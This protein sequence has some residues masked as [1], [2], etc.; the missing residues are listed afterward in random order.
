MSTTTIH[1]SHTSEENGHHEDALGYLEAMVANPNSSG[2][3][4]ERAWAAVTEGVVAHRKTTSCDDPGAEETMELSVDDEEAIEALERIIPGDNN[5]LPV[6]FL[7]RGVTTQKAV[8]RIAL[9][10]ARGTLPAGAGWGT[11]WLVANDLL[12]TNNHVMPTARDA[13]RLRAEFN[14]QNKVDGTPDVADVY[15]FDPDSFFLTNRELDYTVVRVSCRNLFVPNA[16][17][18]LGVASNG[19][20]QFELVDTSESDLIGF[21]PDPN[22]PAVPPAGLGNLAAQLGLGLPG[23]R[24]RF[25]PICVK[26]GSRWG[27]ISLPPGRIRLRNKMHLNVVQHPRGRRKEIAMQQNRLDRQFGNVIRYT[28]DTEPG[29]SGSPVFNNSWEVLALHH[30]GGDKVD[31]EWVNNEGIRIDRIVDDVQRRLPVGNSVRR[32]LGV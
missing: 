15:D 1:P 6:A 25:P 13:H 30:A 11:G 20:I 14:Y 32:Q 19:E 4:I 10:Q 8:A 3:A 7:E 23:Q 29:S 22:G 2:A 24:F 5:L 17:F 21:T 27:H 9:K 16:P 26:P 31:G 28:T 12:I 18:Q